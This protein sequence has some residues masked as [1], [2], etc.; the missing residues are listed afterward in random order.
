MVWLTAEERSF[1][2]D[3]PYPATKSELLD[4]LERTPAPESVK[5]VIQALE[6]EEGWEVV[7]SNP[8]D[9]WPDMGYDDFGE[10]EDDEDNYY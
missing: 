8:G 5:Q 10:N 2:L 3:A 1:L 6:E 4:Y 7:Y 9:I